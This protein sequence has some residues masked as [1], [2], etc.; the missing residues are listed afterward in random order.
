MY[1]SNDIHSF[2]K[3]FIILVDMKI[4]YLIY[5]NYIHGYNMYCIH[6]YNIYITLLHTQTLILIA[7]IVHK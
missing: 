4:S 3:H 1:P 7:G 5:Y 2:M 6:G